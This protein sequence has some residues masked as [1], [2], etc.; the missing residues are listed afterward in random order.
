MTESTKRGRFIVFEG[1]DGSGKTTQAKAIAEWLPTSGLIPEGRKVVLT[2]EPG[3]TPVG[4]TIREIVLHGRDDL[5]PVAELLLFAADRAQHVATVI[6]PALERGDWVVCDR[7]TGSTIAYQGYGRGHDLQVIDQVNAISTGGLEPDLV[8]WL[9]VDAQ[10]AANRMGGR[11]RFE[12]QKIDF[13]RRVHQGYCKFYLS[14][15]HAKGR[16]VNIALADCQASEV[17]EWCTILIDNHL[18][19]SHQSSQSFSSPTLNHDQA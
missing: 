15:I 1:I 8:I 12:R 2:R 13:M 11:D 7:F 6:K 10:I 3:A 16:N 4:A 19:Q 9:S 5:D 14:Q 18:G 17:T